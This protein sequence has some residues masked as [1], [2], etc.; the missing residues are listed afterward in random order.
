MYHLYTVHLTYL[1]ICMS[2]DYVELSVQLDE[3]FN[4]SR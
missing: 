1:R 3:D 4:V 2:H